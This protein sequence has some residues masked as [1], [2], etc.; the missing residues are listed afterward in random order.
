MSMSRT[1]RKFGATAAL[2]VA[3]TVAAP[4]FAAPAQA[5]AKPAELPYGQD[6][7]NYQPTHDWAASGAD[8]GIVKATEGV[9]FK[10]QTFARHWKELDKHKVVRGAYHFGH[11][12][13][14][15]VAEADFFLSVVGGQPAKKGDLL[16][17]D[18]ETDDGQSAEHV[19]KWARTFME[20]VKAKTGVTPIFYSGYA[21]A[22]Q[23][24]KGLSEYPLWVAHYDKPKGQVTPPADWKSWAIHQYSDSPVDQNVSALSVDQLRAL[25]RR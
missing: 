9:D 8:F 25:G 2:A 11:P 5:A 17:L 18:L 10:D 23:Y 24:G 13:N 6:V 21:F 7:S 14:D 15:P 19:N 16:A 12:K 1:L 4:A 20:R 22:D 3:T